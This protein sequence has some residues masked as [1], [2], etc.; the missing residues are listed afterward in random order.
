MVILELIKIKDVNGQVGLVKVVGKDAQRGRVFFTTRFSANQER[1]ET[2]FGVLGNYSAV[3]Y[4]EYLSA[5][6]LFLLEVKS[7]IIGHGYKVID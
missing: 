5:R 2:V 1:A 6:K 3:N 4:Q 7:Y